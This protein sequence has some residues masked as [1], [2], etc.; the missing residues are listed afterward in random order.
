MLQFGASLTDDIRSVN[1]DRNTFII[2]ATGI[3]NWAKLER[4]SLVSSQPFLIFEYKKWSTL[5]CPNLGSLLA[6]SS[7]KKLVG[8]CLKTKTLQLIA[9]M[10]TPKQLIMEKHS[11]LFCCRFNGEDEM[12]NMDTWAWKWKVFPSTVMMKVESSWNKRRCNIEFTVLGQFG[13]FI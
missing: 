12:F 7:S 9:S 8:K 13:R 1:Y 6:L 3:P 4:L 2:Q 10:M 11:S 5:Q